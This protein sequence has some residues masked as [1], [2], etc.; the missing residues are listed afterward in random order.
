[1]ASGGHGKRNYSKDRGKGEGIKGV[2]DNAEKMMEVSDWGSGKRVKRDIVW[3]DE[4]A[5]GARGLEVGRGERDA[6]YARGRRGRR[7]SERGSSR[8]SDRGRERQGGEES[9]FRSRMDDR[10]RDRRGQGD[11][12]KRYSGEDLR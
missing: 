11:H 3:R 2:G 6:G 9:R 5:S 8:S 12:F 1:M 4:K 7:S 10:R